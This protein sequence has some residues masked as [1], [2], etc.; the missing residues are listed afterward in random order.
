MFPQP[1]YKEVEGRE[2]SH[3]AS[4]ILDI[5]IIAYFSDGRD[6]VRVGFDVVLGDDVAQ[7][8]SPQDPEGALFWVQLD[9]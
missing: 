6:L 5:P 1:R 8:L 9:V 3:E 4:D 2:A 7:K